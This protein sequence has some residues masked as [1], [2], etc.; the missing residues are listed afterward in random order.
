MVIKQNQFSELN[1]NF[2]YAKALKVYTVER[3]RGGRFEL[4]NTNLVTH[5]TF[6]SLFFAF[7]C[8]FLYKQTIATILVTIYQFYNFT[9]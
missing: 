9:I 1:L 8:V 3:G 4:Y 2:N 6:F 5:H 7:D